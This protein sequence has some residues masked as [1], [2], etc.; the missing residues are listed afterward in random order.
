MPRAGGSAGAG[1]RGM[2]LLATVGF[3][4]L[5]LVACSRCARTPAGGQET[6]NLLQDRAETSEDALFFSIPLN[7]YGETACSPHMGEQ[8][9]PGLRIAAPG[10]IDLAHHDVFPL[11]GTLRLQAR[12]EVTLESDAIEATVITVVDKERSVPFSFSL[13]P[14]HKEPI[15]DKEPLEGESEHK[16]GPNDFEEDDVRESY[17]NV[18][19]LTFSDDLRQKLQPG[20]YAVHATLGP[21]QSNTVE[22]DVIDSSKSKE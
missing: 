16:P 5:V 14:P 3:S 10:Q 18:D 2:T 9:E 12:F 21:F 4:I 13:E 7:S 8:S 11:C 15:E 17:F 20:R 6:P 22:I 19:L 1:M